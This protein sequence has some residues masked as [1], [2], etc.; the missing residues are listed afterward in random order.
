[1]GEISVP[2]GWDRLVKKSVD[3][4]GSWILMSRDSVK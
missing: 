3:D 2:I 1:M 4:S